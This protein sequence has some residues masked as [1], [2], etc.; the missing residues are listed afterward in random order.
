MTTPCSG[1][2]TYPNPVNS[3]VAAALGAD[4]SGQGTYPNPVNLAMR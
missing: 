3:A 4:R 2:G 1:Q